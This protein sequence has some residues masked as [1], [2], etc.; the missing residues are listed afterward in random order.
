MYEHHLGGQFRA[1]EK[2]YNAQRREVKFCW[3]GCNLTRSLQV[4]YDVDVRCMQ[5]TAGGRSESESCATMQ[6]KLV[7]CRGAVVDK[8]Y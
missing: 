5:Q 2:N 3:I 7:D 6:G 8:V 4:P 1:S